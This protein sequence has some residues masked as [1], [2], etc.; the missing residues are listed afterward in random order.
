M[1]HNYFK[2]SALFSATLL[3]I[4]SFSNHAIAQTKPLNFPPPYKFVA[5]SARMIDSGDVALVINFICKELESDLHIPMV[6]VTIDSMKQ[7]TSEEITFE[8]FAG[9]L[10]NQWGI[11]YLE[12]EGKPWNKGVLLLVS[13]GDR[14][15]RIELGGGYGHTMD[16][17]CKKIMDDEII[18]YFKVGR[19]ADGI[20]FSV[21][22]LDEMVRKV[23][24][25]QIK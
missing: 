13:K 1:T 2:P 10:Y 15:V 8:Q 21:L 22:A 19:Y 23:E 20:R 7:Y 25:E 16:P 5:D 4:S 9:T 6:V 3:L 14:K 17:E 12:K 11:G 18:P 24:G